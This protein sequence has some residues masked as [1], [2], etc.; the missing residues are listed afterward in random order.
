MRKRA[1]DEAAHEADEAAQQA[2]LCIFEHWNVERSPLWSPTI[3]CAIAAGMPWLDIYCPGCRT[4]RASRSRTFVRIRFARSCGR[5]CGRRTIGG[6]KR[7][8]ATSRYPLWTTRFFATGGA[9]P[10][11]REELP[12]C[13]LAVAGRSMRDEPFPRSLERYGYIPGHASGIACRWSG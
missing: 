5:A 11:D 10:K 4:S 8:P 1:A 6:S 13:W 3:G 12:W 2:A 7:R 9:L